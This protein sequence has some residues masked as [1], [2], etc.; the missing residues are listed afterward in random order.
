VTAATNYLS[1]SADL[2]HL[3]YRCTNDHKGWNGVNNFLA[4]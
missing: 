2:R 1:R 3:P 4:Y